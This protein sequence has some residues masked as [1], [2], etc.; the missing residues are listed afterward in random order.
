MAHP[1]P[2][3]ARD[4]HA[5]QDLLARYCWFFDEGDADGY[6]TLWTEDGELSG[7]GDPV[8]GL[9][10]LRQLVEGTYA[11]SK[12]KLRHVLTCVTMSHGETS[13]SVTAKGYNLVT[14]WDSGG[15]LLFNVKETFKLRRTEAGW[16]LTHVHLDIMQ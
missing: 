10:A 6:A 3:E 13:E 1:H 16:R 2:V 14:R 7:F 12:G 8:R 15:Q 11:D 5:I 4:A 9:A